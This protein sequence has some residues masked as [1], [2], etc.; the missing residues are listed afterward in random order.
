MLGLTVIFWNDRVLIKIFTSLQITSFL[1]QMKLL[2]QQLQL[3]N[4]NEPK[5]LTIGFNFNVLIAIF[6]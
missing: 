5:L 4:R 3:F 6:D 2:G 1:K